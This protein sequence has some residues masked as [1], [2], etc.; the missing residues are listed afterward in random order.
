M[1]LSGEQLQK[2]ARGIASALQDASSGYPFTPHLEVWKVHGKIFLIV[3]E[4]DPDQQI[5]TLKADPHR[6]HELR[7]DFESIAP[8]RYLNKQ[9]W[10]S[11]GS[12]TGI[13]KKLITELV[14]DSYDLANESR[15]Q[16]RS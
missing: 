16:R 5:I 3:T 8:G 6:G 12:G 9:H 13:T 1:K 2:H 7:T 11:I 14:Q 10:I 4:N 15:K